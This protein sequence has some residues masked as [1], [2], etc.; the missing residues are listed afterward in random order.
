MSELFFIHFDPK[1]ELILAS[2]YAVLL[3]KDKLGSIKAVSHV[4][5]G[6]ITVEKKIILRLKKNV[7]Q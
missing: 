1:A 5:R 4:N 2:I 6:L 3:H 7:C